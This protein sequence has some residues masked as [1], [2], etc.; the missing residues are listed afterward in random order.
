LQVEAALGAARRGSAQR[1]GLDIVGEQPQSGL[2][3][4]PRKKGRDCAVERGFVFS[5]FKDR[6][7]R[8]LKPGGKSAI[9]RKRDNSR[10]D[11]DDDCK[12][13]PHAVRVST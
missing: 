1:E 11:D 13:P 3:G 9:D 8:S 6:G 4:I 12:Y 10:D 7:W 5:E 2:A